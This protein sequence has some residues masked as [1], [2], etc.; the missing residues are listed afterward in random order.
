MSGLPH[1]VSQ[2]DTPLGPAVELVAPGGGIA[3]IAINGAQL[4]SWVPEG[5][6]EV[7]WVSAAARTQPGKSLRGG[8]PVCW[9]WFG[10]HPADASK[11][12]HGFVRGLPWQIVST[13]S[14]DAGTEA[15]FAFTTAGNHRELWPYEAD[16]HLTTRLDDEGL[17]LALE[18]LNTG[19]EPLPLTQ[20][21]HT[22]FRISDIADVAV[23][24]LDGSPY[25]DAIGEW[26]RRIQQGAVTFAG[27]VDRIY[28]GETSSIAIRDPG[29]GRSILISSQGSGSAVVWNPWIAKSERLGD[30]G[31]D[32]YRTMVCVET[33]N[34]ADDVVSLAPRATHRLTARYQVAV[35]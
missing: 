7:I 1:G 26:Q 33:A 30:M 12:A 28:L 21:L 20:A 34:A 8:T 5:D 6:S 18:T 17:S 11:P 13:S 31:P 32:G 24:G 23:D 25:I 29:L 3:R 10:A 27:E 16:V 4:L 22:Y 14:G 2:L 19:A 15:T 35:L 9:P